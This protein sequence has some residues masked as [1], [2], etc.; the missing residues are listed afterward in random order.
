[1]AEALRDRLLK[2]IHEVRPGGISVEKLVELTAESSGDVTRALLEL[3]HA[4][5]L[6]TYV[7]S[8]IQFWRGRR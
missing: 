5:V 7:S 8:G 3:G 6:R 2:H 4:G 1:M